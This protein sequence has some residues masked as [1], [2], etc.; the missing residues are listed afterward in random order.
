MYYVY[1]ELSFT[2]TFNVLRAAPHRWKCASPNRAMI[3]PRVVGNI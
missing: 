2:A 1:I 3:T